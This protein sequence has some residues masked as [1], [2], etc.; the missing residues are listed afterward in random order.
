MLGLDTLPAW[1]THPFQC[2]SVHTRVHVPVQ[3]YYQVA[4]A[5]HSNNGY[6]PRQEEDSWCVGGSHAAQGS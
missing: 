2:A 4:A 6:L 1:G 3:H 5:G